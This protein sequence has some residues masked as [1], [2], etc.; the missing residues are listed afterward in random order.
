M[1]GFSPIQRGVAQNTPP[2]PSK[3]IPTPPHL[4]LYRTLNGPPPKLLSKQGSESSGGQY[5]PP[6]TFHSPEH[7]GRASCRAGLP[8][9]LIIG[10]ACYPRGGG[11]NGIPWLNRCKRSTLAPTSN[12]FSSINKMPV[13]RVYVTTEGRGGKRPG[14]ETRRRGSPAVG[15]AAIQGPP[16]AGAAAGL[17][18]HCRRPPPPGIRKNPTDAGDVRQLERH[19]R[20]WLALPLRVPPPFLPTSGG[21]CPCSS[22][23]TRTPSPGAGGLSGGG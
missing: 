16:P 9:N 11:A 4:P 1:G 2:P 13:L 5:S 17:S 21:G 12:F 18:Q 23:F 10:L 14:K 7:P 15:L 19:T 20:G 3:G 22:V 8:D 6:P